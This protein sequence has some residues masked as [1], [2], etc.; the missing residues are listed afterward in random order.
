MQERQLEFAAF[1]SL[2]ECFECH[3]RLITDGKSYAASWAR[4][5]AAHDLQAL[6]ADVAKVYATDPV[7]AGKLRSILAMAQVQTALAL[8]RKGNG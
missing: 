8:A 2:T 4:Y 1:D 6:I 5:Q 3:A 7:Y